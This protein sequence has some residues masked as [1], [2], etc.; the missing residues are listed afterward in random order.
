MKSAHCG[1]SIVML[2]LLFVCQSAYAPLLKPNGKPRE[3]LNALFSILYPHTD[4][5]NDAVTMN[6]YAQKDCILRRDGKERWQMDPHTPF[7]ENADQLI[8]AFADLGMV[9]EVQPK[10][11]DPDAVLIHC[12]TW[13]GTDHGRLPYT[14]YCFNT[15]RIQKDS[16]KGIAYLSCLR[17]LFDIEKLAIEAECKAANIPQFRTDLDL[18]R[19]AWHK[20][21]ADQ[22]LKMPMTFAAAQDPVNPDGSRQLNPNG[23]PKRATTIE[24][25]VS[26]LELPATKDLFK[27]GKVKLAAIS[28]AAYAEYQND[29][30]LLALLRSGLTYSDF[31]LQTIG[32]GLEL[33]AKKEPRRVAL[34]IDTLART[35]N[36][37]LTMVKE[38][39]SLPETEKFDRENI[40]QNFK[41]LTRACDA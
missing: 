10:Y 19:Y 34:L 18:S 21:M 35:I 20:H 15:D 1:Y 8:D 25:V 38:G 17:K 30:V 12:S 24:T 40:V 26:W 11:T 37:E 7:D 13:F 39:Y 31:E 6:E 32:R 33:D 28:D 36:T 3:E 22:H 16:L 2:T 9:Y 5:D 29:V 23:T 27:S 41:P 4:F 14:K